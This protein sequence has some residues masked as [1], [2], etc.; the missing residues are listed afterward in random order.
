MYSISVLQNLFQLAT[1][2]DLDNDIDEILHNFE[3]KNKREI[4]HS[5]VFY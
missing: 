3:E 5:I 2:E 1:T 4:L